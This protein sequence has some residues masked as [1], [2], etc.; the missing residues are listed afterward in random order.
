MLRMHE[1][2]NTET[3]Y[4]EATEKGCLVFAMPYR[5]PVGQM[6]WA[7]H[8]MYQNTWKK[9]AKLDEQGTVLEVD[10]DYSM[11]LRE[12]LLIPGM[13]FEVSRPIKIQ[14]LRPAAGFSL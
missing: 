8:P 11:Y 6:P 5:L 14:R 3:L 2:E 4:V 1:Q 7:I 12:E 13:Y 10:S 9:V